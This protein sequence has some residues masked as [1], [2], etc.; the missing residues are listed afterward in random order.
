MTPLEQLKAILPEQYVTEDGDEYK[1]ELKPGLTDQQMEE[2]TRQLPSGYIPA[3]IKE[4]LQFA[5]GFEFSGMEEITFD[6]YGYF[7]M[8]MLFPNSIELAGD[9]FGNFWV[10]GIDSKGNWGNVFFACHDPAVIVKQSDNLAEFVR[11]FMNL[12]SM[13]QIPTLI[14]FMKQQ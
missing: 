13:E 8:D 12:E 1:V 4:L 6:R 10:L 5:S 7:G 9:G 2:L 11:Q 14:T 3:E